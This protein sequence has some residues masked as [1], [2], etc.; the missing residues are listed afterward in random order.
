MVWWSV[1]RSSALAASR[2]EYLARRRSAA[3]CRTC[4]AVLGQIVVEG[5]E[6]AGV[7]VRFVFLDPAP[8]HPAPQDV[9]VL[10]DRPAVR[11]LDVVPAPHRD[12][13]IPRWPADDHLVGEVLQ[14]GANEPLQPLAHCLLAPYLPGPGAVAGEDKADVVGVEPQQRAMVPCPWQ[15]KMAVDDLLD[16]P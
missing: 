15:G 7:L 11:S 1:M 10:V 14:P 4:D 8:C 5:L 2:H 12:R 13:H 9:A 6:L 16:Q 3:R